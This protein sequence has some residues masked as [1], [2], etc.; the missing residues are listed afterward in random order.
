MPRPW[1]IILLAQLLGISSMTASAQSL[2]LSNEAIGGDS[3]GYNLSVTRSFAP[4]PKLKLFGGM[5]RFASDDASWLLGNLSL[6]APKVGS[7]YLS[8]GVTLGRGSTTEHGF[9]YNKL[10]M[11][12]LYTTSPRWSIALS[13]T[14]IDI[15]TT[16]GHIVDAQIT[17]NTT[18]SIGLIY[19]VSNTIDSNVETHQQG[20]QLKFPGKGNT[21]WKAGY[22]FGH[23]SSPIL[24]NDFV[25]TVSGPAMKIR[26][27]FA[28]VAIPVG[29][30]MY[31]LA[32]DHTQLGDTDRYSLTLALEIPV[33]LLGG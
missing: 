15:D 11:E 29:P 24:L 20:I 21:T 22:F 3:S 30:V 5:S 2:W 10:K 12:G 17:W 14:Y 13:D 4:T 9:S 23:S 31:T 1:L 7:V 27:K 16:V 6:S 25:T 26:K 33:D 32:G 18:Q 8:G 28:T 19:S